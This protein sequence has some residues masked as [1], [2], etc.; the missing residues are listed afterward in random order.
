MIILIAFLRYVMSANNALKRY[1]MLANKIDRRSII[2]SND[3][4]Y[5]C[6]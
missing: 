6:V 4:A 2:V 1:V 3:D 5:R